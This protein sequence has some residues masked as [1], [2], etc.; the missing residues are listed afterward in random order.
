MHKKFT[1]IFCEKI[2]I[3]DIKSIKRSEFTFPSSKTVHYQLS[4]IAISD[5]FRNTSEPEFIFNQIYYSRSSRDKDFNNLQ[6]RCLDLT[7]QGK[8]A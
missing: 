6:S 4:V 5:F 2:Y 7:K 1:T 8:L 3:D